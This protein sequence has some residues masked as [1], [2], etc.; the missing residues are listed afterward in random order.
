MHNGFVRNVVLLGAFGGAYYFILQSRVSQAAALVG[1]LVLAIGMCVAVSLGWKAA[2]SISK[3]LQLERS[4]GGAPFVDGALAA[5][6]GTIRPVDG[7]LLAPFTARPCVA[8]EY[9]IEGSQ[10]YQGPFTTSSGGVALVPSVIESQSGNAR[11]LAWPGLGN[12]AASACN[13]EQHRENARAFVAATTFELGPL[14]GGFS[15]LDA[16]VAD[17]EGR[18]KIDVATGNDATPDGKRLTEKVVPAGARVCAVGIWSA[19]RDGIVATQ[20][21]AV[22]VELFPGT[23]D[24]LL[25]GLT[26]RAIG[27]AAG[28]FA[29]AALVHAIAWIAFK[30]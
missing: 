9:R 14:S 10:S 21:S 27:S 22:G 2:T 7:T 12:F 5:A 23:P 16:P 8:C 25:E 15:K 11:L 24:T 18:L 4:L 3:R 29:V 1:A 26:R 28:A 13:E 19:A 30:P 6:A 17:A 20:G